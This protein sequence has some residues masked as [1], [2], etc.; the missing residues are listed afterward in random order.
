MALVI[1]F[2]PTKIDGAAEVELTSFQ[3]VRE[4]EGRYSLYVKNTG[5]ETVIV[6]YKYR[7]AGE[8]YPVQ[9]SLDTDIENIVPANESALIILEAGEGQEQLQILAIRE[10]ADGGILE[11]KVTCRDDRGYR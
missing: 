11:G 6:R 4:R 10:T 3:N 9:F 5:T 2:P 1:D 8:A 7:D